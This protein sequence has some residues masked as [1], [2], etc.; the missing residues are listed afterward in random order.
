MSCKSI[1]TSLVL[2]FSASS[3]VYA[4]NKSASHKFTV[5]WRCTQS[6]SNE[7]ESVSTLPALNAIEFEFQNGPAPRYN[8][9]NLKKFFDRSQASEVDYFPCLLGFRHRLKSEIETRCTSEN[10]TSAEGPSCDEI[11]GTF[12]DYL[13]VYAAE[14]GDKALIRNTRPAFIPLEKIGLD[15]WKMPS[16]LC[17]PG[18]S[19][20]AFDKNAYFA[21]EVVYGTLPRELTSAPGDC[22][23][24]LVEYYL[25][26]LPEAVPRTS[27]CR[28]S[29]SI[30]NRFKE[31]IVQILTSLAGHLSSDSSWAEYLRFERV[32]EIVQSDDLALGIRNLLLEKTLRNSCTKLD[33]GKSTLV[34]RTDVGSGLDAR[35]RLTRISEHHHLAELN[36][37]L[38]GLETEVETVKKEVIKCLNRVNPVY[39]GQDDQTLELRAL[40]ESNKFPAVEIAIRK[41]VKRDDSRN[42][43]PDIQCSVIVHEMLHNLGLVDEYQEAG[44]GYLLDASTGRLNWVELGDTTGRNRFFPINDCRSLGPR[45]SIMSSNVA[46]LMSVNLHYERL[47]CD[48]AKLPAEK[49]R[50]LSEALSK[51][52]VREIQECPGGMV[53]I[54]DAVLA[55]EALSAPVPYQD[56]F[57]FDAPE[58]KGIVLMKLKHPTRA[59]L[60]FPAHFRAITMPG[61]LD[62]NR[63]YYSCA[64]FNRNTEQ[65]T[66]R[67]NLGPGCP[68]GVSAE[69]S[70]F[71]W[72][73]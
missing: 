64:R 38:S 60:L 58:K 51:K 46:A 13:R 49:C 18:F 15:P 40:F 8:W 72:L 35:Y 11:S 59:S 20:E 61:C 25:K 19:F 21:S 6:V 53:F 44:E 10:W 33:V 29:S 12:D 70:T 26:A 50:E 2:M 43:S 31:A 3:A 69:C 17:A 66:S 27:V 47:K 68:N 37:R 63:I 56:Y 71:E 48:C 36:I 52:P 45:N 5:E 73:K 22:V 39:K 57:Y 62:Q 41:D 9:D 23:D 55:S 4:G 28:S 32:F 1:F 14:Q 65:L 30:C 16:N 24:R 42:W 67:K 34:D 54:Q 7:A